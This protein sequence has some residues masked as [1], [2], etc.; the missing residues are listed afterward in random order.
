[1]FKFKIFFAVLAILFIGAAFLSTAHAQDVDVVITPDEDEIQVDVNESIQF[2]VFAY[3]VDHSNRTPTEIDAITW[4]VEPDSVG[5][6]S[7][8]GFFVAGRHPGLAK[9][10]VVIVIGNRTIVK[11]IVVKI[12]RL[13]RPFYDVK[14]IPERAVVPS[15]TEQQFQVV[16]RNRLRNHVPPLFVRWEVIPE[17]LGKISAEGLFVA[18]EEDGH[19]KVVAI[20]EIDGLTFRA[21][22]HV[23]VS[24]PAT[25]AISGQVTNDEG[26]APLEGALVKAIRLG[27]IPW[28]Q[29]DTTDADGNYLLDELIPG[30]YVVSANAKGFIKEFYDDTRN[31]LEATPINISQNESVTGIDFGLTEGGKIT[32]TVVTESDSLPLAGSHIVA[33]LVVNPRVAQHARTAEDGSYTV[34]SLPTGTYAV[35]ANAAGYKSEYFDDAESLSNATFIDVEA[36]GTIDNIDFALGMSSAISGTVTSEVDGSPIVGARIKIFGAAQTSIRHR[37]VLREARTDENGEYIVQV[38]PG[39]YFV[40]ASAENYNGEFYN[41]VRDISEATLVPVMADSHTTNIDFALTPRGA[42]AGQVT[43]QNTGEPIIGAVVQAFRE[44]PSLDAA[45]SLLGFR[46]K[47]DSSGNY[48][49]ENVSSGEYLVVANAEGYLPEYYEEAATKNEAT[50]ITVED[51]TIVD[52]IDFTLEHGGSISGFVA[53]NEDSLPLANALVRVFDSNNDRQKWAYANEDGNYVVSG[54]PTGSYFVQAIADGYF[55]EFYD[56]ARHRRD[57][58]PVEVTASQETAGIDFYLEPF[59]HRRG[60][61]AGRVV[62]AEDET[63]ILGAVV[64]AVSPGA[65]FPHITFTGPR[66]FYELTDLPAGRY[67]VFAWAEKF[68]G[69]FYQDAHLFK[70]ADAVIVVHDQVTDDIDFDLTPQSDHGP[71]MVRG[72]VHSS[73][74][75]APIE[76]V[77]VHALGDGKIEVNAVT[78]AN[79]NYAIDGL[80]AGDYKI[81]AT[82]VGFADG[83]YG[84]SNP[85]N[86]ATVSVGEGEDAENV[87]L[88][89]EVDNV[90]SITESNN[91]IPE[92]FALFQNYPNPFNPETSIKYKLAEPSHVALKIFNVLGQEI[93]TL[94]NED[95]TAGAHTIKWDGKDNFGRPAA[96]GIYIYQVKVGEQFNTARRMLLLK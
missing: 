28:V 49:I 18:G 75:D 93:R 22:A 96:S 82:A 52:N 43:D 74:T 30:V 63:P 14:V 95:Q 42:I 3:A 59:K 38:R 64:I 7:E 77:L 83:Y 39:S 94:V 16:V 81:E 11:V 53:S 9:I 44:R 4:S 41:N 1:M 35:K 61:M 71:Y 25:G 6:V 79:G 78:D 37:L 88:N 5:T 26:G 87:N 36:P 51:N 8:D 31:Y 55:P 89:L 65:R 2:D 24:P 85:Q 46:A 58:T 67:F 29:R 57:A 19:G 72:R 70:D 20:V 76:G 68:V 13:P 15:G 34:E 92:A 12:G 69:E 40:H 33:F 86:A 90:T 56:N 17:N 91:S 73:A 47:T 10:K 60:T 50:L 27:R 23:V 80:A 45:N 66:G 21:S 62:S 48:L 32:G 84:G 54:L